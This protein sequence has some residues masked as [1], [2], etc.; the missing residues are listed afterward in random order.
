MPM[1]Q[2]HLI[3]YHVLIETEWNVKVIIFC[4][5]ISGTCINRNIVECKVV[6][7]EMFGIS[8]CVLIET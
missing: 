8:N 3:H 6:S 7:S 1:H 4:T 2:L 5:I